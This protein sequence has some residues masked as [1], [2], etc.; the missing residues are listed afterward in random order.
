VDGYGP[1]FLR[2]TAILPTNF[3]SDSYFLGIEVT[4][5]DGPTAA[6]RYRRLP[7]LL[8]LLGIL[9]WFQGSE[10]WIFLWIGGKFSHIRLCRLV[11][12]V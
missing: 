12:S 8:R 2:F 7:S 6:E 10:I 5:S 11:R 9:L 3:S 4:L 1:N